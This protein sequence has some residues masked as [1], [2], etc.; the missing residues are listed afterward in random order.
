MHPIR[1]LCASPPAVSPPALA[2]A[3]GGGFPDNGATAALPGADLSAGRHAQGATVAHVRGKCSEV[4]T[5]VA[6]MQHQNWAIFLKR[7][8]F[9]REE[10]R[11]RGLPPPIPPLLPRITPAPPRQ[12]DRPKSSVGRTAG[13]PNSSAGSRAAAGSPS[14]SMAT[15]PCGPRAGAARL[16]GDQAL[17]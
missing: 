2:L 7:H 9:S 3:A 1:W 13:S 11:S 4:T 16:Q 5:V 15:R 8:Q 14:S 6:Q 12:E 10:E 17:R